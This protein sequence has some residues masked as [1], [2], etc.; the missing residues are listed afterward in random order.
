MKRV[1]WKVTLLPGAKTVHEYD[2]LFGVSGVCDRTVTLPFNSQLLAVGAEYSELINLDLG[3]I[4]GWYHVDPDP[5]LTTEA[6]QYFFAYTG[7]PWPERV[8][9]GTVHNAYGYDYQRVVHV[10]GGG[11]VR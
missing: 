11:A 4:V 6:R 10:F 9:V 1:I 5:K 8:H 2:A 3:P 7:A